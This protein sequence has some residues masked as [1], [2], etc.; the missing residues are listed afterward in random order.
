MFLFLSVGVF[1]IHTGHFSTPVAQM[2]AIGSIAAKCLTL[3]SKIQY[4]SKYGKKSQLYYD[5]V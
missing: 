5:T 2:F 4:Q 3:I 1:W